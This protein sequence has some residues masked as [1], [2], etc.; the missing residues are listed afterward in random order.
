MRKEFV[1]DH[2]TAHCLRFVAEVVEPI[3]LNPH[4]GSAIRGAFFHAI[5]DSFCMNRPA[6]HTGGCARCPLVQSCP[7]AF[8][9]A[10]LDPQA[11]RGADVPR[12]YTIQAP[13]NGKTRYLP[14]ERLEFGLTMFARALNLFPYVI[15]GLQRMERGGL[16]KRL[17]QN[18]WRRGT[19][20]LVEVWAE[21]PLTG[22][23]QRVL[24][25]G[26][27]L[28]QV[29]DV[30]ITH[31]QVERTTRTCTDYTDPMPPYLRNS[32]SFGNPQDRSAI[33]NPGAMVEDQEP[34][35]SGNQAIRQP[36]IRN[37]GAMIEED[38]ESVQS[39][40]N[41][42]R[43]LPIEFLTPTRLT[44]QQH[45]VKRPDFRVLF[46]RLMERLRALA[47]AYSDTPL[48]EALR[49]RLVGLAGRVEL[50]DDQTHWVELESYST[51]LRRTTPLG[52]FVGRATYR[53]DDWSPFLPW[54]IWGQFTHV[55]KDAVKGNGRYR[56]SVWT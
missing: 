52:G 27:T 24:G 26:E 12:P 17:A 49:Y 15:L 34:R 37:P 35:E 3:Q 4:Q 13:L 31:E 2:F 20:R 36:A 40:G 48:D 56:I 46:Q 25:T 42:C 22:E 50:V 38:T 9:V 16:G 7:V 18:D 28:V 47:Q 32:Q 1:M 53:A 44:D 10:T 11:D 21:N 51:R 43:A 8:L 6:L 33:R 54:L 29:P 19:F 55:G 45:L 5:T 39:V 30:P 23:R 14:G 41:P